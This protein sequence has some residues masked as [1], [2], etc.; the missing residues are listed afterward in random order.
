M[1]PFPDLPEQKAQP[2]FNVKAAI[3][4]FSALSLRNFSDSADKEQMKH[5]ETIC[6]RRQNARGVM[7]AIVIFAC[8]PLRAADGDNPAAALKGL[9]QI[10]RAHV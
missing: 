8:L 7:A 1:T 4:P 5:G 6:Q 2:G 10:G 3:C 9:S